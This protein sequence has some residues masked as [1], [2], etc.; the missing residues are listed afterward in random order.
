MIAAMG[1]DTQGTAA[2]GDVAES[3]G[4]RNPLPLWNPANN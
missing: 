2:S 4:E 1:G 3:A